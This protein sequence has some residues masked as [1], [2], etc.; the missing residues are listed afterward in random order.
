MQERSGEREQQ[1]Q[2]PEMRERKHILFQ[3]WRG[4]VNGWNHIVERI[5]E[6][7]KKDGGKEERRK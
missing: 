2:F 1:V 5:K 3:E 4:I 6:G 7:S